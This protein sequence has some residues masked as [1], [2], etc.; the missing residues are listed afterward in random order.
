LAILTKRNWKKFRRQHLP[1]TVFFAIAII[2]A[3]LI[4]LP[5][6][7]YTKYYIALNNFDFTLSKAT[8]Y[9]SNV[10]VP[11]NATAKIDI[12]LLVTN[13]TDYSG[14]RVGTVGCDLQYYGP[15]HVITQ[16]IHGVV[17][18]YSTPLWDLTSL[19]VRPSSEII[20]PD[21]NRTIL[22]EAFIKPNYDSP[23]GPQQSVVDFITYLETKPGE[24]KWSI[25][26]EMPLNSFIGSYELTKTFDNVVT[27]LNQSNA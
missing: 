2:S 23:N 24:I 8:M 5:L 18:S 27:P 10:N 14:L 21:S 17:Y 7:N 25:S 12:T 3:S 20:E 6:W 11:T 19:S 22:I 16:I 15:T 13:P 4:I 1:Q 9:A 26:F